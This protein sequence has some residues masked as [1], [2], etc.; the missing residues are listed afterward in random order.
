MFIRNE[1]FSSFL[2]RYPITSTII[3]VNLIIF[4]VVR[5][6][7]APV[8]GQFGEVFAAMIGWN[9]G[10]ERGEYWRLLTPIFLHY[11]VPHVLFN[12]FS[13]VLFGPALERILGKIKFIIAYL[14]AGVLADLATFWLQPAEY[15]H[16]GASGAIFG[17]FGL[18]VYMVLFRK[19]LIDA[20]SSQIIVTILVISLIMTF[21]NNN[22][23]ILGH[24]FGLIGGLLIAPP[25]LS[26]VPLH[27]S[28]EPAVSG[29]GR[30]KTFDPNRWKKHRR[31]RKIFQ[32][33]IW[34][35]LG[36][37]ILIGLMSSVF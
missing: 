26:R 10:I 33:I 31:R 21:I 17:L 20:G 30:S 15:L 16:L 27:Y 35:V 28:W 14:G 1:N 18:Y 4:V 5:F 32:V 11:D 24:L 29:S 23:N 22:I 2:R 7:P 13:L 25:L 3:A 8:G 19:D 37:L 34:G 6:F 12:S 36:V 9:G